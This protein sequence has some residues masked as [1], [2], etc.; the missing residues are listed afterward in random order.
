MKAHS[1]EP[2]VKGPSSATAAGTAERPRPAV[3]RDPRRQ[4]RAR[5]SPS[6]RRIDALCAT[7]DIFALS[8]TCQKR[9][10]MQICCPIGV[11]LSIVDVLL[12]QN[13]LA[14][15]SVAVVRGM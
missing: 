7:P 13:E 3:S 1:S 14:R 12:Q 4:L 6:A 9:R 2:K 5:R 10:R 8:L 11:L 15:D